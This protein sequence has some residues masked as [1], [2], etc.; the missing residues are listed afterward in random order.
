MSLVGPTRCPAVTTVVLEGEAVL[1]DERTGDVH[2]LNQTAAV[3]WNALD[4]RDLN[5]VA[6]T[7]A[8]AQGAPV[9]LV[10]QHV[11]DLVPALAAAG[12]V[13]G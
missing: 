3:I 10:R 1:Y 2:T 13:D 12:L 4:G 7:V 8:A 11:L 9:D 6:E 5:E